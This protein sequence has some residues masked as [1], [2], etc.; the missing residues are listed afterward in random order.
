MYIQ[1]PVELF[2][3]TCKSVVYI[4]LKIISNLDSC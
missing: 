2:L 4:L 1:E 3:G